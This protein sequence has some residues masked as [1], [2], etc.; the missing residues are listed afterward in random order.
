MCCVRQIKI[1]GVLPV[2]GNKPQILS[3]KGRKIAVQTSL[4]LHPHSVTR[5]L[6]KNPAGAI[7]PAVAFE[8]NAD[9]TLRLETSASPR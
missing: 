9:A 5:A 4:G 6:C 7:V 3:A 2:S 1:V 8:S